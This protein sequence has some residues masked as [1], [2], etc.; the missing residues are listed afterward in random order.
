MFIQVNIARNLWSNIV[1]PKNIHRYTHTIKKHIHRKTPMV[2]S[3]Q[4]QNRIKYCDNIIGILPSH[5]N[6]VIFEI[7]TV[8]LIFGCAYGLLSIPGEF[9]THILFFLINFKSIVLFVEWFFKRFVIICQTQIF[10]WNR[11]PLAH[12]L[13]FPW[14][15]KN[16]ITPLFEQCSL[17]FFFFFF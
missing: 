2:F 5:I 12:W 1:Y 3:H 13:T 6:R 9:I 7:D 14:A 8:W 15:F 16:P 17:W 4:V 10:R 11:N